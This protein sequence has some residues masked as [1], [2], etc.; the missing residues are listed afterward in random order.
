MKSD[1]ISKIAYFKKG[2]IRGRVG[3]RLLILSDSGRPISHNKILS[4]K[5]TCLPR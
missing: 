1:I 3:L 5:K 4:L 2:G